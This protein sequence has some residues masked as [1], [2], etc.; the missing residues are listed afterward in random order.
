MIYTLW[1]RGEKKSLALSMKVPVNIESHVI[2][3]NNGFCTKEKFLPES[4]DWY[5]IMCFRKNKSND[6]HKKS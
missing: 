3:L 4:N 2:V 6:F 5:C 1:E